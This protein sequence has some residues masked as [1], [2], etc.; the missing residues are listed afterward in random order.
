[1]AYHENAFQVL[2]FID[3]TLRGKKIM[4]KKWLDSHP[5]IRHATTE[6]LER[7]LE[8]ERLCFEDQWSQIQ[9]CSSFKEI[10]Y[11][12]EEEEIM[13]FLIGCSCEIARRAIIMRIAVHPDYWGRG[14]A[15]K[16]I[17][18]ALEKFKQFGLKC[19]E[20]DVDIVKNGAIKLYEKFGF[21][22]MRVA[23][24]NYEEDT[25]FLIMK[26]ILRD[27]NTEKEKS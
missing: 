17:S 6:D 10:F 19:V 24:V 23:T 2:V 13:G 27:S 9:F 12:F 14:I 8:I 15:S 3:V 16:L 21:K 11:V 4:P 26:L 22:I 18:A 5:N 7:I 25:S 1:L 20:L